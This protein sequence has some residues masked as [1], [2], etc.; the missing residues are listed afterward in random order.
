[1]ILMRPSTLDLCHLRYL[2]LICVICG[3]R[4]LGSMFNAD[5]PPGPVLE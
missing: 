2:R 1:M 3:P 5:Q 4:Y